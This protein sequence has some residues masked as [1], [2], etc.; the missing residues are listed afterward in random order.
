MTNSRDCLW[1]SLTHNPKTWHSET[2]HMERNITNSRPPVA[3]ILPVLEIFC[4][5]R[6]QSCPSWPRLDVLL[7]LLWETFLWEHSIFLNTTCL[8]A[9]VIQSSAVHIVS[10]QAVPWNICPLSWSWIMPFKT[11]S[12]QDVPPDVPLWPAASQVLSTA[13]CSWLHGDSNPAWWLF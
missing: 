2:F 4:F 9:V 6:G 11:Y 12:W 10:L 8:H 13:W 1:L 7:E 3:G 5:L